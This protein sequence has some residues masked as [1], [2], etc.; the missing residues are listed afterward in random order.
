MKAQITVVLHC[1]GVIMRSRPGPQPPAVGTDEIRRL[2]RL[3]NLDRQRTGLPPISSDG[4]YGPATH[5]ALGAFLEARRHGDEAMPSLERFHS[6]RT[7]AMSSY[8]RGD[9]RRANA[10]HVTALSRFTDDHG[11]FSQSQLR[12]E[13]TLLEASLRPVAPARRVALPAPS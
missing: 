1:N 12:E 5:A 8:H 7:T 2:Q 4:K 13:L 11:S 9:W 10:E 6:E 3:I